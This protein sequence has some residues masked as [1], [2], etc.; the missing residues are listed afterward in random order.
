MSGI[1]PD[2]PSAQRLFSDF[3]WDELS[4]DQGVVLSVL[5]G[6][7]GRD[8]AISVHDV[9]IRAGLSSRRTQ[10]VVKEL[11]EDHGVPIGSTSS[12][13]RPGWYL[14]VSE[15]ERQANFV[16]LQERALSIMKRARAFQA[17]SGRLARILGA[18]LPLPKG[19]D[20]G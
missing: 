12:S 10:E 19:G 16:S 1:R 20:H 17:G 4:H 6:R 15:D 8:Q 14:V 13:T 11:V 5:R 2:H 9:A 3:R 18:Q 7:Q